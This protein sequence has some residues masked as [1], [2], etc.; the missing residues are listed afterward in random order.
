M[1]REEL[2]VLGALAVG[3]VPYAL[4]FGVAAGAAGID[5]L[6]ATLMSLIVYAGASQFSAL[7]VI[8]SGGSAL[9]AVLTV[10]LVNLRFIPLGLAMPRAMT[11]TLPTRLMAAHLLVDPSIVLAHASS[12]ERRNRL[13]WAA[14]LAMYVLWAIGTVVGVLAGGVIPDP[15]V[16]GLDA[17]LPAIFV[18]I[19]VPFWKDRPSR[20]AAYGGAGLAAGVLLVGPVALAIPAGVLGAAA[21]LIER[22]R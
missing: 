16:L 9:L 17:A 2:T 3:I 18:A 7:A 4:A 14:S 11:P 15:A 10:W 12:P 19:L 8:A 22:R 21:G 13:F 6:N 20:H 1:N 5:P